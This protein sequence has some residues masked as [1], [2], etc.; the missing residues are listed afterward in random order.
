MRPTEEYN[1]N[2]GDPILWATIL[3]LNK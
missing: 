2:I 3:F 1:Y